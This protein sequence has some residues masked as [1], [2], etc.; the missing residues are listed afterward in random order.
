MRRLFLTLI[1]SFSI[2]NLFGESKPTFKSVDVAE[3]EKAVA[4]SAYIVL[5][6]RTPE[7]YAEGHIPGTHFNIDVL[8]DNFTQEVFANLPKEKSVAL[9]CRSGNRS[10]TAARILSEQG[11]KVIEL[12]TGIRGWTTAG[13]AVEF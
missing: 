1:M 11:Y 9:Y 6:V 3:F 12:A 5:D 7:E 10:K 2:F 13:R 4:D 8:A